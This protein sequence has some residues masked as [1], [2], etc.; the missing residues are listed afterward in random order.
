MKTAFKSHSKVDKA[1]RVWPSC[2]GILSPV[3]FDK[4]DCECFLEEDGLTRFEE[5]VKK[6]QGSDAYPA[7]ANIQMEKV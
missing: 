3:Y 7:S 4:K 2:Q 6:V 1:A 5:L